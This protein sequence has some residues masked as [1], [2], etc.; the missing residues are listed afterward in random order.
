MEANII[1]ILVTAED[2]AAAMVEET[3]RHAIG[4][5]YWAIDNLHLMHPDGLA[6][7]KKELR[8]FDSVKKKW[9]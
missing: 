5:A 7:I 4:L 3:A 9:K 1:D 6:E 2:E 8:K